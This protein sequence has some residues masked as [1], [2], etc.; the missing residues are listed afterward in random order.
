MTAVLVPVPPV[1][2]LETRICLQVIY[3]EGE[4]RN[5]SEGVRRAGQRRRKS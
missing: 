4:P 1:A 2:E 3:L 5:K